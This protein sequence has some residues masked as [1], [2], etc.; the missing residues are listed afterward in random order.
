[1]EPPQWLSDLM[2]ILGIEGSERVEWMRRWN[3][4]FELPL[5][6]WLPKSALEYARDVSGRTGEPDLTKVLQDAG[7]LGEREVLQAKARMMGIGYVDLE[8]V[9][10]ERSAF[11]AVSGELVTSTR[12]IPVKRDGSTIWLAMSQSNAVDIVNAFELATGCRVLPVLATGAAID[13]AIDRY[14]PEG[15]SA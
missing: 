12:S 15:G 3:A 9:I 1:M 6:M 11:Q 8:R 4:G 10:V 5:E 14:F 13:K 7:Y 2:D